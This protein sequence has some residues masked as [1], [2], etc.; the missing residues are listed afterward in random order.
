MLRK[1][2]CIHEQ[3]AIA[4]LTNQLL[5]PIASVV[6]EAF[7]GAFERKKQLSGSRLMRA[8]IK[9]DKAVSVGNPV[10]E[11][12][13]NCPKPVERFLKSAGNLRVL[14]IG[15]S[16][17]AVAIN[18]TIPALLA[19]FSEHD[20]PEVLHQCGEKNLEETKEFYK[21]NAIVESETIK[22]QAFIND[23]AAAYCWADI[24][25]CRAGALTVSEISCVGIPS[26]LIPYPHAVDNH[27]NENAQVLASV[28]AATVI[29]QNELSATKL[30][31]ILNEYNH[32][33]SLI[34]KASQAAQ[35]VAKFNV[36]ERVVELCMEV[37][38]A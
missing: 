26:I 34:L 38:Y 11:E 20:R 5:F 37:S 8:F 23:M 28:G 29:Q 35:T 12:I 30:L 21:Q 2:L 19:S 16:L 17:G 14:V 27:Q 18:K 33:R 31:N 15:G 13:I 22:I 9:S 25:I 1:K 24:I 6:M 10:R 7:P 4:G 36:A 32:D 3:N